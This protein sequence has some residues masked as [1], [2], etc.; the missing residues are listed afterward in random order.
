[1]L[2]SNDADINKV[3]RE[4][5]DLDKKAVR[6]KKNVVDKAQEIIDSAKKDIKEIEKA[7]LDG[8]QELAKQNYQNEIEKAKNERLSI[9]HSM[10]QEISKVRSRYDEKKEEKVAEVLEKLFRM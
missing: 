1:M 7:E 2:N 8:A 5:I 10:E 3:I 6:I 4:V 9:I